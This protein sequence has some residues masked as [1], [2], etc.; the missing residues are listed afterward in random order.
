MRYKF[1]FFLT[2]IF[3]FSILAISSVEKK[4]DRN[5]YKV[6]VLLKEDKASNNVFWKIK[7][8]N[9][10][11]LSDTSQ[12]S[13]IFYC[14]SDSLN[15][16][17]KDS[18]IYL[19]DKKYMRKTV[20][21][22]P[23]LGYLSF[24][25]NS[26]QG[27][28]IVTFNKKNILL[29]NKL[30]LE[31]YIFAV[32]RSESWPG[33][34]IEVNKAFSIAIRSYVISRIKEAKRCSRLYHI[35]NDNSHQTYNGHEYMQRNAPSLRKAVDQT[36]GIFLTYNNEPIEALYDSCC[37]GVVPAKISGKIDFI[38]APYLK[39]NYPCN[40]CKK[41]SLYRWEVRYT[42]DE[43]EKILSKECPHIKN[44][45]SIWISKKDKAGAVKDVTIKCARRSFKI[46]GEKLY[47][48]LKAVKSF[49]FTIKKRGKTV[50]MNGR[51]YGHHIGLCQ[52]GA[53]Q[54]VR[55]LCDYKQILQFYY[56]NTQFVRLS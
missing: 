44:I 4:C 41:C 20:V 49:C 26:Y 9:G 48:F 25:G 23:K 21:I 3:C 1:S 18:F 19:N 28:F 22:S 46:S 47:S 12:D 40:Y 43:L 5:K 42:F 45:K 8:E 14:K 56:P 30:D 33:W 34:P 29:I 35:K 54:M 16:Q 15:V 52:W 13:K 36:R 53:R 6:Q 24:G 39:R 17:V 11:F 50:T 55:E 51:G 10:F 38:K 32:L 2:L 37:G 7:S 27:N 31:D